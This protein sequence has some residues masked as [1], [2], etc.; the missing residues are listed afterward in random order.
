MG[1]ENAAILT[2]ENLKNRPWT[3]TDHGVGITYSELWAAMVEYREITDGVLQA[4]FKKVLEIFD[5]LR[6]LG[7][8][9]YAFQTGVEYVSTTRKLVDTVRDA[10]VAVKLADGDIPPWETDNASPDDTVTHNGFPSQAEGAIDFFTLAARRN[11]DEAGKLMEIGFRGVAVA[12]LRENE[13][14][15]FDFLIDQH[16]G[17]ILNASVERKNFPVK[18]LVVGLFWKR[19]KEHETK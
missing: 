1:N 4:Y 13:Q 10:A 3:N 14:P 7:F 12:V 5:T 16:V 18:S 6:E 2:L 15:L 17:Q 19:K 11:F 8:G 9:R